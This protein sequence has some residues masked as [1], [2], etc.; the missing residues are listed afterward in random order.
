MKLASDWRRI[1]YQEKIKAGLPGNVDQK[2][3]ENYIIGDEYT[4]TTTT[5]GSLEAKE[6]SNNEL[7]PALMVKLIRD[8]HANP[9]K[10]VGIIASGSFPALFI[11]TLAALQ[12]MHRK[13]VIIYSLGASSFGANQPAALLPDIEGWI[14]KYGGCQYHA[15]LITYGAEGDTAGGIID[16]GKA[17]LDSTLKRNGKTCYIPR[18]I[19]ES[20][21]HKCDLFLKKNIGLLINIG[22]NQTALGYCSHAELIP[23]G[24]HTEVVTCNHKE[25]GVISRISERH[26]PYIH[27]LN[28]KNLAMQYSIT[29]TKAP[30]T[31]PLFYTKR[32]NKVLAGLFIVIIFLPVIG[33]K[34]KIKK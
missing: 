7:F 33:Y 25:R 28:I 6:L 5:L 26:I 4:E 2:T 27:L 13:T 30:A 1:V 19:E 18:T 21:Q 22:G 12:T 34:F 3:H 29:D 16:E 11:E 20:V 24:L 31:H 9:D 17:A 32:P 23:N 15:D 8:S 14:Q 10:P